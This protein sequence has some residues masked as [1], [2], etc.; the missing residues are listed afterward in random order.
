MH[1]QELRYPCACLRLC[2]QCAYA[3]RDTCMT[4]LTVSQTTLMFSMKSNIN[5]VSTD[6][7][8]PICPW[9]VIMLTGKESTGKYLIDFTAAV[10][11]FPLGVSY[12]PAHRN[13]P[14]LAHASEY[15]FYTSRHRL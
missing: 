9:A 6:R 3:C 11:T 13:C 4:F 15:F 8:M 14:L 5:F 1:I 12:C 10:F 2:I 7:F